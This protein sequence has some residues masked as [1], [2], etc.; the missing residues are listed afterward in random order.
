MLNITICFDDLDQMG[1]LNS[2]LIKFSSS[3]NC[4]YKLSSFNSLDDLLNKN[5]KQID[6]LL[7]NINLNNKQ[8]VLNTYHKLTS[9]YNSIQI[10]FIPEIVDFMINGFYLKDFKYILKPLNYPSFEEE[11][12][13]CIK[14]FDA[15]N[16]PIKN[17]PQNHLSAFDGVSTKSILFIESRGYN[18]I[19]YTTNFSINLNH[20]L[21]MLENDLDCS[22]FF[23]C[24][25]N[26]LINLNK[27]NKLNRNYVI[28]DSKVVPVSNDKFSEL[29]NKLLFILKI[30]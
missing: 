12:L 13:L 2:Y 30:I 7:L 4:K 26:Y 1:I 20:S 25:N 21:S 17:I 14:D 5:P 11:F 16:K 23:R 24:H 29:K 15:I 9:L 6:I 18:C 3:H 19:A 10:I 27:I 8:T 28:I 22:I